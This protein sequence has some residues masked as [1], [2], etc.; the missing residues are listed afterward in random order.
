VTST[1]TSAILTVVVTSTNAKIGM[2]TGDRSGRFRGLR[3]K[4][5]GNSLNC[6]ANVETIPKASR[7]DGVLQ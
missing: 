3:S 7:A 1:N 4:I 6:T 5:A 2:L